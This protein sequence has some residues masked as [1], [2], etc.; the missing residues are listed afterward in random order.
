[1][2]VIVV[3]IGDKEFKEIKN[4]INKNRIFSSEGLERVRNNIYFVSMKNCNYNNEI[5]KNKCLKEIPKQVVEFYKINKTSPDDVKANKL[6]NIN[7]SKE[8]SINLINVQN[9]NKVIINNDNNKN[10]VNPKESNVLKLKENDKQNTNNEI[11]YSQDDSDNNFNLFKD[12]D[13]DLKDKID[14]LF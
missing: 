14:S 7:E 5:L 13:K 10:N 4:L 6:K 11:N 12:S 9:N 2:S 3:G 1:L 8:K